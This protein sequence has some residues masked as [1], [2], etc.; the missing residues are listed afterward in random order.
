[1]HDEEINGLLAWAKYNSFNWL[2]VDGGKSSGK[3]HRQ[4]GCLP[5]VTKNEFIVI[6]S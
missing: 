4:T 3:A 5:F 2:F 6:T 1:M